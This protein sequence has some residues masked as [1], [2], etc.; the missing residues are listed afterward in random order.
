MNK[1]AAKN[2]VR[3]PVQVSGNLGIEIAAKRERHVSEIA[4][5]V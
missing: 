2:R 1:E 3:L 4:F 5:V